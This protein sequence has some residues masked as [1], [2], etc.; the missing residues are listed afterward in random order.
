MAEG[1]PLEHSH[2]LTDQIGGQLNAGFQ[3]VAMY[4]DYH[5]P[6]GSQYARNSKLALTSRPNTCATIVSALAIP[7][8]TFCSNAFNRSIIAIQR[9]NS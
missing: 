7:H 6:F 4:E 8:F 2:T 5:K 9:M 1:A 3:L